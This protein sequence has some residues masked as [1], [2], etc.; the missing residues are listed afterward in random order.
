MYPTIGPVI[1][2]VQ[3][4][5]CLIDILIYLFKT[6]EV[7]YKSYLSKNLDSQMI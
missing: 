4:V 7:K 5:L 3:L 1:L 6:K 2:L